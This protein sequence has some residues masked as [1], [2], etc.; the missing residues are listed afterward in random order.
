MSPALHQVLTQVC[1]LYAVYWMLKNL[2]FFLMVGRETI[3]YVRLEVNLY[4][5]FH[6]KMRILFQD[7]TLSYI[8]QQDRVQSINCKM[9]IFLIFCLNPCFESI[10]HSLTFEEGPKVFLDLMF[11][12]LPSNMKR[13]CIFTY[14][15]N[16]FSEQGSFIWEFLIFDIYGTL[17]KIYSIH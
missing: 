1:E 7:S 14:S 15:I 9:L 10:G 4:T 13:F 17:S 12:R 5:R 3:F 2:G 11:V 16:V 6:P 8:I